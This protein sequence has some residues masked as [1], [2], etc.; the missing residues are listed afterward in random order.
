MTVLCGDSIKSALIMW[1]CRDRG[2][3]RDGLSF[4]L[5]PATYDVTVEFDAEGTV[6]FIIMEPGG[7]TLA[8][9]VE[10]FRM[11]DNIL[12]IAHDKST[13]ARR[14]ITV[15]NTVIDPGWHGFLTLELMN[16]GKE[17]VRIKRGDPIAQIV[18]HQLDRM[19]S[20]PYRGKY[21]NQ[22]RGPAESR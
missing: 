12:A 4:G 9:T 18:F 20:Q 7:F 15:Q 10:K 17:S 14:G 2:Y 8:S 1:P 21:Q 5:G 16:H 11:P 19:V 22:E 13:W 3:T 6:E